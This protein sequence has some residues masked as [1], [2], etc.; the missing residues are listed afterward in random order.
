MK[1]ILLFMLLA[2]VSQGSRAQTPPRFTSH[3]IIQFA[4]GTEQVRKLLSADPSVSDLV[5]GDFEIAREDLNDDGSKEMI[6]LAQGSMW[7]GSGGC[8]L[9]VLELRSGKIATILSGNVAGI[10]A[11]TN[12]KVGGY[13]ALASVDDKGTIFLGDKAGTPLFREQLVYPMEV[14]QA[15]PAAQPGQPA[16]RPPAAGAGAVCASA[17]CTENLEF[18]ATVS[19]FRAILENTNSKTLTVRISFR[20]KLNRPLSVGYVT[21]SG[22]AIDD[23]GN[24]YVMSGERGVQGIGQISGNSADPK[25]TLQP[26]ESSD[27]R[28]E[29]GWYSSGREIFGLSFQLDLTIREIGQIPNGTQIRLGREYAL[30]FTGLGNRRA[31]ELHTP[32]QSPGSRPEPR[33]TLPVPA[34]ADECLGKQNCRAYG[35]FVAEVTSLTASNDYSMH[36]LHARLQFR[37]PTSQPVNLAYM[38]ESAV[39]IDNHG[40]RYAIRTPDGARGIGIAARNQIDPQFVV[41]PGASANAAFIL[42]RHHDSRVHPI[43]NAF[44]LDLTIAQLEVLPSQQIRVVREHAVGFSELPSAITSPAE[45][46]GGKPR[47]YCEGV[48]AAELTALTRSVAGAAEVIETRVQFRNPTG[49]PVILAYVAQSAIVTDNYGQRFVF[50]PGSLVEAAGIGTVRGDQADPQF[51]LRPGASGTATFNVWRTRNIKDPVGTTFTFDLTI[52]QLEVLPSRQVRTV[53]DYAVTLGSLTAGG[54][55]RSLFKDILKGLPKK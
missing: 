23:R 8:S 48:T 52:A 22:V 53:R 44:T 7:C 11:V 19:D 32:N 28:F 55:V 46:C 20:N 50:R 9:V 37:N 2:A 39:A 30:H 18:A 4:P 45:A 16:P 13:R 38:A 15:A 14:A 26:G 34:S 21:G 35:P 33:P 47:S 24:R 40:Q 25:F 10:L 51:V 42:M 54:G 43:G 27:A 49:Q 12:E 1:T 6:L 29:L 41:E 17:L 31:T 36:V 3:H 5:A